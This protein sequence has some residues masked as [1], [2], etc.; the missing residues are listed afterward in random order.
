MK[1]LSAIVFAAI[2]FTGCS[3]LGGS[4]VWFVAPT[5]EDWQAA[6]SRLS[7]DEQALVKN[8]PV[9]F[10]VGPLVNGSI[11]DFKDDRLDLAG[12]VNGYN[13]AFGHESKNT[14]QIVNALTQEQIMVPGG[15]QKHRFDLEWT[16]RDSAG[17]E[18]VASGTAFGLGIRIWGASRDALLAEMNQAFALTFLKM[19]VRIENAQPGR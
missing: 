2:A 7:L 8:K 1:I 10:V 15:V 6:F 19:V 4:K 14:R 3:S 11:A 5:Q 12:I 13:H 18:S 17:R 16:L 9:F